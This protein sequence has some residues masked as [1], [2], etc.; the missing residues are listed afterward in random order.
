VRLGLDNDLVA[1]LRS[2]SDDDEAPI[3]DNPITD[4]R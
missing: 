4:Y 2:A 1:G 3:T